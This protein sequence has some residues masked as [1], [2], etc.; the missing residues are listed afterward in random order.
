MHG[1]GYGYVGKAALEGPVSAFF[2]KRARLYT[3][4]FTLG[5]ITLVVCIAM[6]IRKGNVEWLWSP[7]LTLALY[8][9]T[10]FSERK[11]LRFW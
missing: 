4:L 11:N 5:S 3:W 2:Q 6:E 8:F 10:L 9:W 1:H 7:L